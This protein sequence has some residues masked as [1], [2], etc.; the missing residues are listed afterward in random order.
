MED[1]LT[2]LEARITPLKSIGTDL[3]SAGIRAFNALWPGSVAPTSVSE[4]S[5]QLLTAESRL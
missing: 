4:L 5:K 2:A 3:L 1:H